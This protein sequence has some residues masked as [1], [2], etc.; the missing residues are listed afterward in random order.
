[1]NRY[2]LVVAHRAGNDLAALRAA[3]AAG[4][5]LVEADVWLFRGRVEVR[6]LK[7]MG[8]LPL[9]WDRWQLTGGWSPRL[10]L[11][12]L[13]DAARA[14]PQLMLDLKGT[15]ARLSGAVLEVIDR[16]L[17]HR[18]ITVCSRNWD[19]L[20]AFRDR[21]S[22]TVV[23]SVGSP[24][25]LRTVYQHLTWHDHHAISI[26]DRLLTPAVVS[27]LK[28]RV[29]TIMTWPVTTLA[30]A[31]QLWSWGVDGFIC[32]DLSLLMALADARNQTSG[33]TRLPDAGQP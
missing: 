28:A 21:P 2:P 32:D 11:A 17:P 5:D 8:R 27:A 7:T 15:E 4:A 23:H 9:L 20:P 6:H 25:Q 22:I 26:H 3:R 1:M 10:Q 30:R 19:L 31:R 12:E 24:R 33:E 29:A 18:S 13:C 16:V 14:G